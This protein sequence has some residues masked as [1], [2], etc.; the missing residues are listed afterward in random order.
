VLGERMRRR[1]TELAG[2][3]REGREPEPR[4][5]CEAR[6]YCGPFH[7]EAVYAGLEV[8]AG[9]GRCTECGRTVPVPRRGRVG[10]AA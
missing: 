4:P 6:G 5:L 3:W 2:Q 1:I 10:S 7:G 8:W 9:F